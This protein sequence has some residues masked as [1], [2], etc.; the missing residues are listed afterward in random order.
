MLE[1]VRKL[2]HGQAIRLLGRLVRTSGALQRQ[3]IPLALAKLTDEP[4]LDAAVSGMA[5]ILK[6]RLLADDST[7][8]RAQAVRYLGGNAG[9]GSP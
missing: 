2:E 4:T 8:V 1:I 9:N 6:R 7:E 3:H 5:S